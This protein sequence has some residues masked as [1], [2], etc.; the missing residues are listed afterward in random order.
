MQLTI[1]QH[2]LE[3]ISRFALFLNEVFQSILSTGRHQRISSNVVMRQIIFTGVEALSLISLIAIALGSLLFVEGNLVLGV[4][5]Q[6]KLVY[7]FLSTIIIRELS[8]LITAL[9]VIARS[10][11]AIS[12]ELGNMVVNNEVKVLESIGI[13]PIQY[14]VVSR[15]IGV[16]VATTTLTIFFNMMAIL[17]GWIVSLFFFHLPI[18]DYIHDLLSTIHISDIMLSVIKSIL[19]GVTIAI[20]SCYHGL[21][22]SNA[23]TEVPQRTIKAVVNSIIT[24]I[25]MDILLTGVFFL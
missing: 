6:G 23:S 25:I 18:T 11:T 3:A 24:I 8:C 17:G 10:G 13:S 9:I 21:Q 1:Y 4:F 12:T 20:I 2:K 7:V 16:V 14:L 15:A 22:V 19:F 5:G